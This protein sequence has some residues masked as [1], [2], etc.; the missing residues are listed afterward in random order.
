MLDNF[1]KS[2][3]RADSLKICRS[4]VFLKKKVRCNFCD[5][6]QIE[7]DTTSSANFG[8]NQYKLDSNISNRRSKIK[9]FQISQIF[10]E[11]RK[12]VTH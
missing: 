11:K 2:N 8:R 4:N 7:G 5:I 3:D 1:L 10:T 6:F 9:I 12:K